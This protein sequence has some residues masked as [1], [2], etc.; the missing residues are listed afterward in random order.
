MM[1]KMQLSECDGKLYALFVQFNDHKNHLYD[2][3]HERA[4]PP[5]N[6]PEGTA[7][8]E[9]HI[10]ISGDGGFNWTEAFN[11]TRSRTP[12]CDSAPSLGGMLECDA[13]MWPSMSRFGMPVIDPEDFA[14]VPVIDPCNTY[15][16]DYYLDVLYVNDKH[17]GSCIHDVGI[18]TTNPMKWFRMPCVEAVYFV[19]GDVNSSGLVNI[20]DVTY[21]ICYIYKEGPPPD[22]MESADVNSDCC[23]NL[24]DIMRLIDYLYKGGLGPE[25]L[26]RSDNCNPPVNKEQRDQ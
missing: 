16:G 19:C 13:D 21:L 11:L 1:V 17:P 3:C 8:G 20:L 23:I 5:I 6:D 18:W 14:D 4:F 7:N 9:L 12:H 10:A 24:H 25:C 22:P 2:D 15:T 26:W